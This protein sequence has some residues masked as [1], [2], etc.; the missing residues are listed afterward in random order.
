[1][2]DK[3]LHTLSIGI[4]AVLVRFIGK[5]GLDPRPL[6]QSIGIDQPALANPETRLTS[7][8]FNT[9]WTG[10]VEMASEPN[11]G[12]SFANELAEVWRGKSL[13]FN[14][15]MNSSTVGEAL[16]RLVKYHD[17]VSDAVRPNMDSST[18]GVR[19]FWEYF[20]PTVEMP[21]QFAEALMALYTKMLLRLTESKMVLLEVSFTSP[22][23]KEFDKYNEI[24]NAPLKFGRTENEL[25]LDRDCLDLPIF[26]SD[27]T[28][29]T[30]LEKLADKR[31][32]E[33]FPENTLSRKVSRT[34]GEELMG[35]REI[36]LDV[37]ARKLAMSP[38]NLQLKLKEEGN[39]Y[40]EVLDD[41]RK[42]I[43]LDNLKE[44]SVVISD[45]AFL[46]GYSDQ[47]A[48]NHAFKRWTGKTPR[49]FRS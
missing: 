19:I 46:L 17:I 12:F 31:L 5:K 27:Q 2:A 29:L 7:E 42:K 14:M 43:A 18:D 16:E 20:G 24:F 34:I 49:Q 10:I 36:N 37:V 23:P 13:I 30:T 44:P 22:A 15:M 4:P 3:P 35:G 21:C 39:T 33:L 40:Q 26:L 25:L 45:L 32:K 6:L 28:V 8:Q 9:L 38:R 48:F 41:L 1:M 11:F 47:S